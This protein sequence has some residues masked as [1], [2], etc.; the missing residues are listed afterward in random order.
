MKARSRIHAAAVVPKPVEVD[1]LFEIGVDD[2]IWQ[3]AGLDGDAEDTPPEWLSNEQVQEGIKAM[4]MYTRGKEE[5]K[6][7]NHEI[8]VLLA[9]LSQE[10]SVF[11]DP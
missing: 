5:I 7:L 9:W 2:E 11:Q 10:H 4:L 6:V 1:R 3:D 8:H